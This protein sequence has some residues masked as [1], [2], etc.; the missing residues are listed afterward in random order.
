MEY[1]AFGWFGLMVLFLILESSTVSLISVWFAAGSLAAMIAALLGA[2]IWLQAVLFILV[3]CILLGC[4][5][6]FARR[7]LKPG[8][9]KTN[10]DALVG[11][12][13]YLLETADNLHGTGRIKLGGVEW[14][15]RSATDG[16]IPAGSLVKVERIE[17]VK[18]FVREV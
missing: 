17:G 7:L 14:T 3:S 4:L 11:T 9:A 16:V 2:Q 5:R 12:T 10:A 1:I 6:P 13:G 8:I 18:V 15:A